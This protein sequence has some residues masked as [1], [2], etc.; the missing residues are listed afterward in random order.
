MELTLFQNDISVSAKVKL[1]KKGDKEAFQSLIWENK[2]SMYRIA[3]TILTVEADIEDAISEA[4]LKAYINLQ[5][6]KNN[7]YFKT[8]LFRILI[9]ECNTIHRKRSK[10]I[11]DPNVLKG[12][13]FNENFQN[14]EVKDAVNTL[15]DSLKTLV[16]LYYYEDLT[17]R[18]ISSLMDIPEG[19][20][21]T[22]LSKARHKLY[23]LLKEEK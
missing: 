18:E 21:K 16:V 23:Q 22:R 2:D 4:V 5:T 19:T 7:K 13:T 9:N 8:W 3:K 20:I 11:I 6:L 17:I 1:A 15:D 12:T 10:E 14:F